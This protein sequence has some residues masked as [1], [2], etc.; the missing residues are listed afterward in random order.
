[1]CKDCM[2]CQYYHYDGNFDIDFA[3]RRRR[4]DATIRDFRQTIMGF[5][6]L[7]GLQRERWRKCRKKVNRE[8]K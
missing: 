5:E 4:N 7:R 1:M 2:S 3:P 8:R 6:T